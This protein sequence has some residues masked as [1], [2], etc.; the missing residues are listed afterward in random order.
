MDKNK[1]F[2]HYTVKILGALYKE[3]PLYSPLKLDDIAEPL[4]DFPVCPVQNLVHAPI[5][6][7]VHFGPD[8]SEC[9]GAESAEILLAAF[10]WD[11]ARSEVETQLGRPLSEKE[12]KLMR[13]GE[14][15]PLY[16]EEARMMDQW[17][18][19]WNDYKAKRDVAELDKEIVKGTIKFLIHEGVIRAH[20]HQSGYYLGEE[21]IDVQVDRYCDEL[22]FTLTASGYTKMLKN[23]P[24]Y[25]PKQNIGARIAGYLAARTVSDLAAEVIIQLI[26]GS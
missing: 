9:F 21:P 25:G 11:K 19:E 6:R 14:G 22:K 13:E 15:R 16:P 2:N 20:M 24:T 17:T 7:R 10:D 23:D 5:F 12:F 8:L 4:I 3:F 1:L 26:F 18:L